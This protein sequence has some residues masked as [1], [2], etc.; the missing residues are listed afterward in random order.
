MSEKQSPFV[1]T[2]FLLRKEEQLVLYTDD[3]KI[4]KNEETEIA[5][6]LET[7]FEKERLNFWDST[8][9]F[10]KEAAVWAAKILYHSAQLYISKERTSD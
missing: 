7:E 9:A 1:D 8:I 5:D 4:S 10:H 3:F 2:I 6:Y